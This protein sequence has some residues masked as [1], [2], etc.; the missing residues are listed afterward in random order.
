M[1]GCR[2][3]GGLP[4]RRRRGHMRTL[5]R[6]RGPVN[7]ENRRRKA[8]GARGGGPLALGATAADLRARRGRPRAARVD[9][10]E[11]RPLFELVLRA[12]T[13]L[14]FLPIGVAAGRADVRAEPRLVVAD[15]AILV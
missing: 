2:D 9:A 5:F 4:G 11:A 13:R 6:C 14:L 8:V 1:S 12:A 15:D 7:E 10:A 3:R